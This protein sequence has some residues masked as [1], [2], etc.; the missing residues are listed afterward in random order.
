MRTAKHSRHGGS[1]CR[2]AQR[3]AG[4]AACAALV[5]ACC[6]QLWCCMSVGVLA[7]RQAASVMCG[8]RASSVLFRHGSVRG[9]SVRVAL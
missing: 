2:G 5:Q 1:C 7:S 4:S 3:L 8:Q 6:M 9:G